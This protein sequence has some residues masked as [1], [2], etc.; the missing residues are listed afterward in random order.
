MKEINPVCVQV[1]K[2]KFDSNINVAPI[3][4]YKNIVKDTGKP[5]LVATL[6]LSDIWY[7]YKLSVIIDENTREIIGYKQKFAADKLQ[8]RYSYYQDIYG[9]SRSQTKRAFDR[10]V[11]NELITREFRN[12]TTGNTKLSGVMYVEPIP[13]NVEQIS[14]LEKTNGVYFEVKGGSQICHTPLA[15]LSP[16]P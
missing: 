1:S 15:N 11:S 7:W 4:W 12:I 10:L 5:D 16:P 2:I 9:L 8:R 14:F 6:I 3:S 13:E